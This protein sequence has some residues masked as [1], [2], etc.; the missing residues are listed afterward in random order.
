MLDYCNEIVNPEK[1]IYRIEDKS[2]GISVG[3]MLSSSMTNQRPAAIGM[4]L[5]KFSRSDESFLDNAVLDGSEAL[6][7]IAVGYGHTS[8]AGMAHIN[9]HV[10]NVSIFDSMDFFYSNLLI[11][12]QERSTR[13]Q[14]FDNF[15]SI[16]SNIGSKRIR[17]EYKKI[18]KKELSN[19]RDMYEVTYEY[20]KRAFPSA[21][22]ATLKVRTLDCTRYLI[23]L[24]AKTSFGAVLSARSL[25]N[26][27]SNLKTNI[28]PLSARLSNLLLE[29]F[30]A[31]NENYRSECSFLLR[32]LEPSLRP[33]NLIKELSY[34]SRGT[35][36]C[37][38]PEPSVNGWSNSNFEHLLKLINPSYINPV[39]LSIEEERS[40]GNSLP[41]FNH[42]NE[43]P[44]W[45]RSGAVSVYGFLDL[46]SI[47]DLN[48]HR[49]LSRLVPFFHEETNMSHEI[50]D[51]PLSRRFFL[52]PY[53]TYI[54]ELEEL[55]NLYYNS[56]S[57]TYKAIE[58]W[59]L[60]ARKE[61]GVYADIYVKRLVP[62]AHATTYVYSGGYN[63]FSYMCS[64]R[65]K[66]GGHIQYRMISYDISKELQSYSPIF[67][68]LFNSLTQ[69]DPCNE[70]E[71]KDRS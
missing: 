48:R 23:P 26:Y 70:K 1:G 18:V 64:L 8:V 11:D 6:E 69:P 51:R 59:Y 47:K 54:K 16:P 37:P 52:C 12:G 34:I 39:E 29:L 66:P 25:A 53:L 71:F 57:S 14:S 43:A 28:N 7:K 5:A 35:K 19:Y 13:Y 41:N 50:L 63:D 9:F 32:H 65:T 42:H 2:T 38:G 40:I 68:P 56:L 21:K 61:I 15:I 30:T 20:L 62:Q 44:H 3:T 36:S 49:S 67:E 60:E 24:A 17:N 58:S 55:S 10:E 45:L 46:G 33:I 22:E 31:D 4:S 27:I